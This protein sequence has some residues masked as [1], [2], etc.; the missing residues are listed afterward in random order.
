MAGTALLKHTWQKIIKNDSGAS[1]I[2]DSQVIVGSNEFNQKVTV[3][4]GS[5]VE[6]DCGQIKIANVASFFLTADQPCTVDTNAADAAG[7][8]EISLSTANRAYAWSTNEPTPNPLT[9]D[10]TKIY[11]TNDSSKDATFR[12]GFLMN[13]IV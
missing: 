6:V 11:V 1:A 10:I 2:D 8:Q 5:T 13:L 9:S 7:G 3:P 12:A 4:A